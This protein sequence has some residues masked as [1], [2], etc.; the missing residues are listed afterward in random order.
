MAGYQAVGQ[1]LLSF[2]DSDGSPLDSGKIYIGQSG[3]NPEVYPITVYWDNALTQPAAQPITTSG[4]YPMRNA[5]PSRIYVPFAQ[6][7][8]SILVKNRN[9]EIVFSKLVSDF[10]IYDAAVSEIAAQ[11]AADAATASLAA[12]SASTDA[13]IASAAATSASADAATAISA[14][15]TAAAY[16]NMEWA[17]FAVSDGDLIVSY[18]SG[19]TSLPSLVDGEFIIT[20]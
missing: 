18:V 16:A 14:A 10:V 9:S 5:S 6:G 4:G 15:T 2:F 17:S 13:A 12:T 7:S 20:Y 19:A 1:P 11:V 3:L 8:Y